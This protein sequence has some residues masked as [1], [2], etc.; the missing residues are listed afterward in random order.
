[1]VGCKGAAL[2]ILKEEDPTGTVRFSTIQCGMSRT[3]KVNCHS[4]IPLFQTASHVIG[5]YVHIVGFASN[6]LMVQN[7][8]R[9]I[10][11]WKHFYDQVFTAVEG[12]KNCYTNDV[13]LFLSSIQNKLPPKVDFEMRQEQTSEMSE[14]AKLHLK[15]FRSRLVAYLKYRVLDLQI[16]RLGGIVCQTISGEELCLCLQSDQQVTIEMRKKISKLSTTDQSVLISILSEVVQEEYVALDGLC[17]HDDKEKVLY[18]R[19]V[20][21]Q[22]Y[23]NWN[24]DCLSR[25][26]DHPKL[27]TCSSTPEPFSLLP[28]F[29]LQPR[30]VHYTWSVF[31]K[32]F[33]KWAQ[34]ESGI[35][36]T[37]D[38]ILE[39]FKPFEWKKKTDSNSKRWRKLMDEEEKKKKATRKR[40]RDDDTSI[41]RFVCDV[42]SPYGLTH[43]IRGCA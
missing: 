18:K 28:F 7:P 33:L 11:D 40:K 21:L 19:L 4:L 31:Y 9:K 16:Q 1:M 38:P 36:Q 10:E 8:D 27:W 23:S 41:E 25:Y 14:S 39:A 30:L 26:R 17:I 13:Q 3:L 42:W 15:S 2:S 32:G 20:H 6:W 43:R 12:G 24:L 5:Q 34:R 35:K 22:R 29:K 37:V